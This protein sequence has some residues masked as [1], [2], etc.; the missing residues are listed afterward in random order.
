M[1]VI[2]LT[3]IGRVTVELLELNRERVLHIRAADVQV[4]RHP[5]EGDPIHQ[6]K[7]G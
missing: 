1:R 6:A 2:P 5:P 4:D 7:E 3:A